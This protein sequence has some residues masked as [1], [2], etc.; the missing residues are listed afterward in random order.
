MVS[1]SGTTTTPPL[2]RL[3]E[4]ASSSCILFVLLLISHRKRFLFVKET[5]FCSCLKYLVSALRLTNCFV[6]TFVS[7]PDWIHDFVKERVRL[8]HLRSIGGIRGMLKN[9]ADSLKG[10]VLVLLTGKY[11]RRC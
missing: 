7:E 2:V 6:C 4:I 5:F 10:W 11:I 1:A 9:R 3:K 8:R